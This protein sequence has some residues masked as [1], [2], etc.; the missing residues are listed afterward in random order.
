MQNKIKAAPTVIYPESDGKPMAET[1][2]HRDIMI[3]FI[4]MLKHYF[5]NTNDVH[6]SGNLLMYYEEGN[7]RKSV[8]PDVF[9]AFGVSKKRRRTYKIWEEGHA[10][11]FVLEVASPSTYRHDLTR[12]KDLYASVLGVRE[13]YIYDPYHEVNP[14]FLGYRLMDGV[15]QEIEFVDGRLPS[16]VLGLELGERDGVFGLY[17]P[18]RS[19]WLQPLEEQVKQAALAQQRADARAER[20]DAR[21]ERAAQAQQQE[22]QARQRTES[23][24]A[25]T[26]AALERLQQKTDV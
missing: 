25:K 7:P 15:Y 11:D 20:A 23:E 1:E 10:P 9:V 17:D 18:S 13:Y 16:V 4:Q 12:K 21:A 24:L 8:S 5:R 26:L 14:Y 6:V 2:S 3:D 19:V 22:A